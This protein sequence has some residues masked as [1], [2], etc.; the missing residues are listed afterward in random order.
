MR[1]PPHSSKA[2][3]W[4][5][6][7]SRRCVNRA[8]TRQQQLEEFLYLR[9]NVDWFKMRQEQKLVSLNLDARRQQKDADEAFRKADENREGDPREG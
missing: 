7:F 5:P 9:K 8:A 6:K 4:I 1:F 2:L 3:H